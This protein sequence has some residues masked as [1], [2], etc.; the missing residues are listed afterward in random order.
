MKGLFRDLFCEPEISIEKTDVP[1]GECF[2]HL[3]V[4]EYRGQIPVTAVREK[5]KRLKGGVLFSSDFPLDNTFHSLLF[6]ETR[7]K[8]RLLMNTAYGH[9]KNLGI[10]PFKNSLC[11]FDPSGIYINDIEK[12]VPLFSKIE[13]FTLKIGDYERKAAA[14]FE[15]YGIRIVVSSRFRGK[16]PDCTVIIS[17]QSL[18]FAAYFGGMIFTNGDFIPPCG[19]ALGGQGVTLP[20]EYELLRPKG[21]DKTDFAAALYEKS[22]VKA[23]G[24]L[25]YERL[26]QY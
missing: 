8:A 22:K 2:Y 25:S 17:P 24:E 20:A 6:G 26:I 7:F 1:F 3:K 11:I 19:C 10:S 12:L 4:K 5:L 21:I 18:P 15:K 23:L 13:V 9:I 16:V 14:L